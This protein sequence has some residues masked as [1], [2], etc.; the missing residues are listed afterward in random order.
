MSPK[1]KLAH[2][3]ENALNLSFECTKKEPSLVKCAVVKPQS[4]ISLS[5]DLRTC[6]ASIQVRNTEEELSQ[7]KEKLAAFVCYLVHVLLNLQVYVTLPPSWRIIVYGQI[8]N[9]FIKRIFP[10][11]VCEIVIC[12]SI[13]NH[14]ISYACY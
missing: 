11:I 7:E 1:K 5:L 3:E 8:R 13:F 10:V 6:F 2:F 12:S 14:H 4:N 9:F